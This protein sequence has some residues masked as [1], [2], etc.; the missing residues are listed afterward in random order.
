[1]ASQSS[2]DGDLV[3]TEELEINPINLNKAPNLYWIGQLQADVDKREVYL[4]GEIDQDTGNAFMMIFR[5]MVNRSHEPITIWLNTPGG[6]LEVAFMFYDMVTTSPAPVTIIG[7]GSCCS[8]GV[9][10]L[11]C[12]DKRF[13]AENC[14]VMNHESTFENA[15]LKYSEAKDRRKWE[16]WISER[17]TSLV[18]KCTSRT[19][20][21]KNDAYWKKITDKKAEYWILGGQAIVDEG[22]ADAILTKEDLKGKS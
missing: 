20:P 11:A 16:D 6:D 12:G 21:E 15:D 2:D 22:L 9:L 19:K 14:V 17:F 13:V 4:F 10:M 3:D 18:G 5:H 7:T 1:M 8:A